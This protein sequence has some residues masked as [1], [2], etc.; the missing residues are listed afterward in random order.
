MR[1]L[2]IDAGY[3]TGY[4]VVGG[5]Q[6]VKSGSYPIKE[7]REDIGMGVAGRRFDHLVRR[8]ILEFKPDVI[9][10]AN[11][12]VGSIMIKGRPQ[13]VSSATMQPIMSWATI[14]EMIC[15]ELRIPCHRYHEPSARNKFLGKGAS[16]KTEHVK[17]SVVQ[18]C[19]QRGWPCKD[20]HA[21]DALC[22]AAH[23]LSVLEPQSSHTLTPLFSGVKNGTSTDL[24]D[25]EARRARAPLGRKRKAASNP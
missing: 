12:F 17:K 5:G 22:I 3:R 19:K 16:H 7:A 8:L 23:A 4:G 25:R 2:A 9:A 10:F 11:P 6:P 1:I 24:V 20:D 18:A 13:P 14:I 15:D 21:G